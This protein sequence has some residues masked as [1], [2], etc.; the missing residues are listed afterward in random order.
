MG[1]QGGG[2]NRFYGFSI[3]DALILRTALISGCRRLDTE[4]LQ[5][6]FRVENMEVVNPFL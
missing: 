6:G 4:D 3:W 1:L 2:G 5:H